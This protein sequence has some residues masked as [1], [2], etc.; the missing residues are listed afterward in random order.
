MFIE[1]NQNESRS[2]DMLNGLDLFSGIGGIS[3]ALK[4]WVHTVAYCERDRYAQAVLLSRMLSGDIDRAPIWDDITTL[5]G[6]MLPPIDIIYGGFPCQDASAAGAQKGMAGVRTSLFWQ[7]ARLIHEAQPTFIFLENVPGI[8]T[9]GLDEIA[10]V[11][12]SL[13]FDCRWEVLSAHST[14]AT[15]FEGERWFALGQARRKRLEGVHKAPKRNALQST[16][17]LIPG[18]EWEAAPRIRRRTDAIPFAVD[19]TRALGNA[20]VPI[21][22]KEAFMRLMGI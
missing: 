1:G 9:N 21:Q 18:N 2:Q 11:I 16:K 4:D 10:Q 12:S 22:A 17:K 20:V 8:C 14:A 7:V 19:R 13:G 3:V 5:R 6:E 15:T